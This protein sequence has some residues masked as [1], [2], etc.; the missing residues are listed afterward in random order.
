ML[1][2]RGERMQIYYTNIQFVERPIY[3]A[4]TTQGLCYV[5]SF[6]EKFEHLQA[7]AIKAFKNVTFT[8]QVAESIY[9]KQLMEY[10]LGV[11]QQFTCPVHLVGTA[12]QKQVWQALQE[13]PYG[14]TVSYATI[15]NRIQN[16]QAVRAVGGAIGKNP[17]TIIIPCH[18][19]ISKDG[20]LTGFRGG[21]EMKKSLLNLEKEQIT[22]K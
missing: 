18:R 2:L 16:P 3:I 22:A 1:F 6:I 21:L 10:E 9:T 15:A 14:E 8:E 17:V 19:V 12:F 11:R 5:G 4:W 20:K 7:W 13:I